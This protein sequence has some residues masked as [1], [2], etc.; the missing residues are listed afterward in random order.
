ML[1]IYQNLLFKFGILPS[2]L[3]KED[4]GLFFEVLNVEA[5]EVGDL[6]YIDEIGWL[7]GKNYRGITGRDNCR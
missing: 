4:A 5:K 6:R 7:N 2:Q 3:D 1:I